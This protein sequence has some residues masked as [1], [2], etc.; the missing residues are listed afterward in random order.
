MKLKKDKPAMGE[1]KP[2]VILGSRSMARFLAVMTLL[3]A[4]N[5]GQG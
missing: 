2:I 1:E 4:A 3:T 5:H